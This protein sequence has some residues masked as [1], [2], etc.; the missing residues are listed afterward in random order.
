[1]ILCGK[2]DMRNNLK[3]QENETTVPL[4]SD[5]RKCKPKHPKTQH[6]SPSSPCS[7]GEMIVLFELDEKVRRLEK[8]LASRKHW[9]RTE[10]LRACEDTKNCA[11]IGEP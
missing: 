7:T 2:V 5:V 4:Y 11:R 10:K 8:E 6:E 9:G 3:K 1:M